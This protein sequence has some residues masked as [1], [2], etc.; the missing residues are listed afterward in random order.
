MQ[1]LVLVTPAANW[2]AIRHHLEAQTFAATILEA[3]AHGPGHKLATVLIA[4]DEHRVEEACAL[5]RAAVQRT[6]QAAESDLFVVPVDHFT[7]T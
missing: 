4:T 3:T 5:L 1:L 6:A 7:K 2:A